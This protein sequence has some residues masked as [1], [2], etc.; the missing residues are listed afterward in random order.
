MSKTE[1]RLLIIS[2][3]AEAQGAVLG[4]ADALPA[5]I[6]T[7]EREQALANI[8]QTKPDVVLVFGRTQRWLDTVVRDLVPA[9]N[10]DC[11][12][13]V[14]MTDDN[15][16]SMLGCLESG[17]SDYLYCQGAETQLLDAIVRRQVASSSADE[18]QELNRIEQDQESGFRVQQTMLPDSPASFCGLRFQ[19]KLFPTMIMSGDFVDYFQLPDGRVAFYIAD[20]SG[21]GASGAF[22]TVLLKTLSRRLLEEDVQLT[23][24]GEILGWFNQELIQWQLEQHVTMFFGVIDQHTNEL[25]YSNAAHFPGTI[26]CHAESAAFLNI[27]GQ[28]LGLL[29]KVDYP[30]YKVGLPENYVIAMFS[31][32]V[33]EIMGETS[34]MDKEARLLSMVKLHGS[35]LEPEESS[36]ELGDELAFALGVQNIDKVPDDIAIFTVTSLA[37]NVAEHASIGTGG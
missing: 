14:V 3:S 34:L 21:H 13:V 29:P 8:N 7:S 18:S 6:F 27:G 36:E 24:T 32:G 5:S 1:H 37:A 12:P 19:H 31:D 30:S 2:D 35:E 4:I 11:P 9:E 26:L 22:V 17:A 33:F 23:H 25:E 20:V 28:P 16:I 15:S 10:S